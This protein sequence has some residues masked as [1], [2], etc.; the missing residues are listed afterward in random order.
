MFYAFHMKNIKK[1]ASII[2]V[3]ALFVIFCRFVLLPK[4]FFPQKYLEYVDK[5]S[6]KY[7]VEPSLVFAVMLTESHFVPDALS[8][9][10]AKGLMQISDMTGEWG[11]KEIG[12]EGY[13]NDSLYN[14]DV[15]IEI[16]CWYLN[17]L[18]IQFDEPLETA[19]AAYNAGS[20]N[21]SKWLNNAQYSDDGKTL[22]EIPYKQTRD[23]VKKVLRAKK[24]YELLYYKR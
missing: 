20:G 4:I 16:G 17:K 10:S 21:V 6:E 19:L 9:K 11:A 18:T 2:L 24:M 5:Y 13:T 7:A 14:P 23:Y 1:T 12:I 8:V 15:N 3:F 22:K